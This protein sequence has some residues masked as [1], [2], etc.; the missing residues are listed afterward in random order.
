MLLLGSFPAFRSI[1]LF[2]LKKKKTK[3]KENNYIE[4]DIRVKAFI[5]SILHY[6]PYII[7]LE[8]V[9]TGGDNLRNRKSL[10]QN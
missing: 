1:Q 4:K 8:N 7:V 5:Y 10:W 6:L 3:I 2:R 9:A